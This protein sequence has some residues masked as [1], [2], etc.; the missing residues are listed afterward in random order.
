MTQPR[1]PNTAGDP[2]APKPVLL[3]YQQEWIADRSPL[4][5]G[6]KS[7]RIGYTWAEAADD[8]LIAA[9]EKQPQNVYYIGYNQDMAIEYIEA[10]AMWSRAFDRAASQIDEGLWDERDVDGDKSIKSY[11]IRYPNGK[12]IVALSSRPANLRGKQGVVVIDEAAF[13]DQLGQLLKAALA[14]LIWGG[15]VRV[16]STHFGDDNPFN[17]LVQDIRA[18]RKRGSVHHTTFLEAVEQGLYQRVCERTGETW[19]AEAEEDWVQ[20]VYDFYGDDAT[21]ELDVVPAQSGG[22]YIARVVAEATMVDAE[23][24]RLEKRPEFATEPEHIRVAD[25][26]EWCDTILR[27]LLAE[28]PPERRHVFGEDFARSGDLTVYAPL[29]IELQLTRRGPFAVEL[30]G[31]PF[32]QQKQILFYLCDRLPR[33]AGGAMDARGNGQY[34]AEV[35]AQRYGADRIHQVMLSEPWYRENMPRFRAA[36][37]DQR[38]LPVRDD[39]ILE[40]I[41][42]FQVINGTPKLPKAP[43]QGGRGPRRHGDAGIA[44]AL[45]WYASENASTEFDV[46]P[47]VPRATTELAD[48]I[49]VGF[50]G[51]NLTGFM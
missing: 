34:L 13:H 22:R 29:T 25:I 14:L 36:L 31:I 1:L 49:E 20:S 16:L 9:R 27:P 6:E 24:A 33:F 28:L 32:E 17:E 4:K 7:R 41:L 8:V 39:D 15:Q 44:Y 42:A 43:T 26:A 5:I 11:T 37:E 45:A 10:C 50:G 19:S 46:T 51:R 38:L 30:R 35:A 40:D 3:P 23:V 18:G 48:S 2:K 12:R 21:E 47:I